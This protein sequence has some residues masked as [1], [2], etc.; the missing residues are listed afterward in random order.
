MA[1]KQYS[2]TEATPAP[3]TWSDVG[4]LVAAHIE[5][6]YRVVALAASIEPEFGDET[7][8]ILRLAKPGEGRNA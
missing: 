4:I 1:K 6:G 8:V 3:T 7:L 2:W 5:Q